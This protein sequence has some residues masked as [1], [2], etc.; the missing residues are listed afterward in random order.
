MTTYLTGHIKDWH[1]LI[2]RAVMIIMVIKNVKKN[3]KKC[4]KDL[5]TF[6]DTNDLLLI[7]ILYNLTSFLTLTEPNPN[8]TAIYNG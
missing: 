6:K 4:K 3:Y 8:L 7:C 1:H 2:K 5:Q